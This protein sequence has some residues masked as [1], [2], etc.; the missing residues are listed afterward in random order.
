LA[1]PFFHL[2]LRHRR[3]A[4]QL[5]VAFDLASPWTVLF[6]SSGSGKTTILQAIQGLLR[7]DS[8]E[9]ALHSQDLVGIPAH[10]RAVRSAAQTPRLFPH[11]TVQQNLLWGATTE[12][13]LGDVLQLFEMDH[14]AGASPQQ[15]SGG[16]RQRIAVAR[17]VLSASACPRS[18]LLLDEPFSGLDLALRDRLAGGLRGWLAKRGIPVLSVTHD[19][20]EPFLL[21]AEVMR[22]HG[23]C[24]VAHGRADDALKGERLQLLRA[25]QTE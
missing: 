21:E 10:R 7:P 11:L 14:R 3:G 20:A 12:A 4:L 8:A 13:P 24:I 1:E 2:A 6:G 22:L 16:E 17:A 19:I 18:L 9:I 15:L 23:G 25:L 5:D